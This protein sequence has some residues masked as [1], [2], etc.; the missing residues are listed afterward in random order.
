MLNRL[1]SFLSSLEMFLIIF[2]H[3]VGQLLDAIDAAGKTDDTL[4]MMSSD[5]GGL[6][7]GHG[8]WDDVD[9]LFPMFIKGKQNTA[10]LYLYRYS[11]DG[12]MLSRWRNVSP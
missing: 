4:V 10:F 2:S 1:D 11:S 5:H 6:E 3:Q 12:S 8:R 7:F 9:L